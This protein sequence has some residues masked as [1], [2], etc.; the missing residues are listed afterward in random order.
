MGNKLSKTLRLIDEANLKDPNKIDVDGDLMPAE[1]V[2]GNR[3]SMVLQDYVTDPSPYLQ[4]AARGQHIE[5]W[6]SP[7]SDFPVGKTGYFHWRNMLKKFHAARVSE[8]MNEA[9]YEDEACAR[10]SELIRKK[11]LAHDLEVQRLEDVVVLVFLQYY[12][13]EFLGKHTPEKGL[14]VMVKTAKKMSA[15]GILKASMITLPQ[16][17]EQVLKE[18][19][20]RV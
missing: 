3:M 7:R 1:H 19:L 6:K 20:K 13:A 8:I 4:I 2:Y 11:G 9:G 12:A 10:V 15:N 16:K 17:V 18:A 5:R 14:D